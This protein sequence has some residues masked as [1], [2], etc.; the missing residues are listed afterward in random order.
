MLAVWLGTGIWTF[1]GTSFAIWL[2]VSCTWPDD[3]SAPSTIA[4]WLT[5]IGIPCILYLGSQAIERLAVTT[6][7]AQPAGPSQVSVSFVIINSLIFWIM[8]FLMV[9]GEA[10]QGLRF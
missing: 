7:G 9:L 10:M 3:S 1:I 4:Y 6:S 5:A 8:W 2:D